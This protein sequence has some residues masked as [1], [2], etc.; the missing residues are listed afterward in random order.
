MTTLFFIT[1]ESYDGQ[2]AE[3]ESMAQALA[4]H[5][6]QA[7][8]LPLGE[9]EKLPH[10]ATLLLQSISGYHHRAGDVLAALQRL[11]SAGHRLINPLPIIRWNSDKHYL[12]DLE[13]AGCTILP[14]AWLADH[15]P[16]IASLMQ[17]LNSRDIILKPAISAGAHETRRIRTAPTAND[18]AW[19]AN[20]LAKGHRMMAQAFV[21]E[22]EAEGEW[23]FLYFGGE[24]SHTVLKTPKSGDWRVQHVHGGRYHRVENPPAAML[25]DATRVLHTIPTL[26]GQKPLYARVDGIQRNGRLWLM[27]IELIE[28]Y[29]YLDAQPGAVEKLAEVLMAA[30]HRQ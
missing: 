24:L 4:N 29:L 17:T 16:G 10:P 23:S 14:T 11:E 20:I 21:P 1:L 5:G 25:Q 12:R 26:T 19:L 28:P 22:V 6:I 15:S 30:V 2:H 9:A 7:Q 18:D 13:Q 8:A 27:E 3:L